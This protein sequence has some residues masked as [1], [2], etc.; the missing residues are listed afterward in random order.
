MFM[1]IHEFSIVARGLGDAQYAFLQ[2]IY[3]TL[4]DVVVAHRGEIIKYLGDAMLCVFPAD[5]AVDAV[6]CAL[7][8][9]K[10][11]A[12]LVTTWHITHATELEIGISA[13]EVAVGEFG[14][15]SLRV[16]DVFSAVVNEA[17]VIGH[18]R[19]IAITAPI[20]A[21]LGNRYTT[22]PLAPH[23][24]KWQADPLQVWDVE[25]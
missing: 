2:A 25:A 13:G 12:D 16:R 9:R 19:G 15:V 17:A 4:G 20:Q 10:A 7:A 21:A 6:A 22:R 8:L 1:D 24:V 23:Q 18:H 5:V 3:E 11:Y 14:H